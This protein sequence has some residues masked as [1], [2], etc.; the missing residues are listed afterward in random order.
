MAREDLGAAYMQITNDTD[1]TV[2]FVGASAAGAGRIEL[3][4]TLAGADGTMS[5]EERTEGFAIAPGETLSLEPGGADLMIFDPT[6]VGDELELVLDFGDQ[7]VTVPA[8][9]DESQSATLEDG[10]TSDQTGDEHSEDHE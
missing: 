3:H 1:E 8:A 5:M 9:F 2:V 7:T 10:S 4:E 6:D